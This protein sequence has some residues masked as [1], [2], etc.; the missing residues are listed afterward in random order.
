MARANQA[1]LPRLRRLAERRYRKSLHKEDIVARPPSFVLIALASAAAAGAASAAPIWPDTPI[2]R[3]EIL[4]HLLTLNADLL[5]HD[6]ATLTLERWCA[7]HQ[8]AATSKIVADR[9][10]G[11]DR[12]V[13]ADVRTRLHAD[14]DQSI[15]HRR[16]KLRCG[17]RILSEADNWYVPSRLTPEMNRAL[18]TSDTAFGRI[19][20]P[21]GFRRHTLSARL[22]WSPLPDGWD[23]GSARLPK[24]NADVA[25]SIPDHVIEHRA[26]LTRF[27]G[28]PFSYVVETYAGAILDFPPA[29]VPDPAPL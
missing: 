17:D 14:P 18:A 5:S 8:L 11:D 9:V 15:A 3:L 26:L 29:Q 10:G 7:R 21:L 28:V 20:L 2:S 24:S 4:A 13:P 16:V 27:D 6:S 19:V 12:E 25:L 23:N 22:L 1:R